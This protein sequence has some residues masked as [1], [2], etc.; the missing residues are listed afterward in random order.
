MTVKLEFDIFYTIIKVP[1]IS[2]KDIRKGLYNKFL[3]WLKKS[4]YT[5][6]RG[7]NLGFVYDDDAVIQWLKET[8]FKNDDIKILEKHKS[9]DDESLY[10][11]DIVLYF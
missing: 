8:K 5:E 4:G 11:F 10:D 2:E 9:L 7:R 3:R 6:G 1:D